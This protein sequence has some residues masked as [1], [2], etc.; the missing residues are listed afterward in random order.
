MRSFYFLFS[1]YFFV[2]FTMPCGDI[3]E[4]NTKSLNSSIELTTDHETHDHQQESCSPFCICSCCGTT[5]I[6]IATNIH[7]ISVAVITVNQFFSQPTSHI[8][9]VSLAIWQPPQSA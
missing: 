6:T 8:T 1:I 2:I 7:E 5:A 3:V 4:R 9:E